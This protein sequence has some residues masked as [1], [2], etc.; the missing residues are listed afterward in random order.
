ML[1]AVFR[2][3]LPPLFRGGSLVRVLLVLVGHFARGV[4]LGSFWGRS[5]AHRCLIVVG[6]LFGSHANLRLFGFFFFFFFFLAC[7]RV[8]RVSFGMLVF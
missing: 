5:S 1:I 2:F 3:W 8:C 4:C 6:Y 7:W